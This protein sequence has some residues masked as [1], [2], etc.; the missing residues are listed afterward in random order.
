VDTKHTQDLDRNIARARLV[1]APATLLSIYLDV[2]KP[3]L[4]PWLRLSGGLLEID[5]YAFVVLMLHLAYA[6]VT[7]F[8]V[9]VRTVGE[10]FV[11]VTA[12]IDI[13]FAIVVAIFTEGPTSPSSA[14]F[15]F[16]IIAVGCRKGFRATL[17]VTVCSVLPYLAL[18]AL[19]ADV[20]R[21]HGYLMRPVYLAITGYLIGFLGQQRINFEARVRELETAQE[22]HSIARSLHDGY[23]QALAAVNL[24]LT[25]CHQ[26]LQKGDTPAAQSQL[27]D[28]QVG[29]AREYDELRAYVRSLAELDH[30]SV[31]AT[32]ATGTS[33]DVQ[34]AFRAYG[35]R[36]EQILLILLEGIRNTVR[37]AHAGAAAI[38]AVTTADALRIT[39]EDDGVGFTRVGTVPWSIASR[40]AELGGQVRTAE[41]PKPGAH[42]EIDLPAE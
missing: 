3:D 25:G 19:S 26:L 39:I 4:A 6:G 28:L 27:H 32:D 2:A 11:T 31:I 10:R 20:G 17:V 29:V 12:T 38:R 9:N 40:V 23:I 14:F 18:I 15:A 5:R 35:P 34:A 13:I 30:P 21:P 24:R 37:H 22:R 8:L 16:A 42:L 7:H 1:L 33:F 36:A 41:W